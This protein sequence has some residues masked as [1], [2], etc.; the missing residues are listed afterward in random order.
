MTLSSDPAL[1]INVRNPVHMPMLLWF[2]AER[3]LPGAGV[4]TGG[5]GTFI[6]T[7]RRNQIGQLVRGRSS[8]VIC[9]GRCPGPP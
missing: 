7:A 3:G 4:G 8:L 6:C 1:S 5:A 2:S 9:I